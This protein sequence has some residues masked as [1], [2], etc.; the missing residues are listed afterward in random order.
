VG[1]DRGTDLGRGLTRAIDRF[2]PAA[3]RDQGVESL[4]RARV[5]VGSATIGAV[6]FV[7]VVSLRNAPHP[8]FPVVAGLGALICIS[9]PLLLRLTGSLAFVGNAFSFSLFGYL[10]LVTVAS[11][12]AS[13]AVLF[14]VGFVP[15]LAV[16]LAGRKAGAIWGALTI[17]VVGAV[18]FASAAGVAFPVHVD[19]SLVES[20]R[21]GV[22]LAMA[23]SMLAVALVYESFTK[24]T[25]RDLSEARDVAEAAFQERA[26]SEARFR[27]LTENA[28]DVVAEWDTSGRILYISPQI[29]AQTGY[30][31]E[32]FLG[33]HWRQR[34]AMTHP[35]EDP[36]RRVLE[37]AVGV[38][39]E[40][41]V[42][43]RIRHLEGGSRWLELTFRPFRTA[44]GETHLVSIARDV[45]ERREAE[46]L[47]LLTKQLEESIQE[48]ERSER[49]LRK[50]EE[51]YRIVAEGAADAIL[52]VDEDSRI[53][54]ANPAAGRIFGYELTE[55]MNQSLTMLMP[56]GLRS[57]HLAGLRRY[58]ETGARNVPW[59][60]VELTGV[61][62][63][64]TEI[65]L[66]ISFGEQSSGGQRRFIGN[67]RDVS[68]RKRYE[69]E[70]E[71]AALELERRN[72]ELARANRELED[73]ASVASHDLQEPLR[74]LVSFSEL[75]RTDL[76]DALP[77]DAERDLHFISEG[78]RRMQKLVKDLLALS[79]TS[80]S[81]MQIGSV[82]VDACAD[83]ALDGLALLIEETGARVDR[84][85]L[86]ELTADA[87]LL[88]GIY[89]NLIHNALKFTAE[90]P[91][92]ITLTARLEDGE[93]ILGVRDR[94]MG[95]AEEDREEIFKPFRRLSSAG[96]RDGSGI[97]LS[98]CRRAV[99]RHGGRIWVEREP[100]AG[101]HLRFTLGG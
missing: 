71:M 24:R 56:E 32:A 18:A 29:T 15:L 42:S 13:I 33:T 46:S 30:P 98:F 20:R 34:I 7:W 22:A 27:A 26:E 69:R 40:T 72:T 86:P 8:A 31:P 82:A 49:A 94:G 57:A 83:Q 23:L 6:A 89:Q 85:A 93:W 2:I 66:E 9:L 44:A 1:R 38:D 55:L 39:A 81:A 74:K 58:L 28:S 97:G 67:L 73:F 35:D 65:P 70:L 78:A 68:E 87:A 91:P 90:S 77:E 79:R 61:R 76:G 11:G 52:A 14:S 95:I 84:E 99:E 53:R 4:H 100:G 92:M 47:R 50:S 64:Q 21:F 10:A 5:L 80:N 48:R 19:P 12:G 16:L 51:R 59:E 17:G 41:H 54:F 45:T 62:K 60:G 36:I 75:L 88:T 101:A 37:E 96:N 25:L 3:I 43:F 63:D